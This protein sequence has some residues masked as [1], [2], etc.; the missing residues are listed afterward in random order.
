M[1]VGSGIVGLTTAYLL[2]KENRDVIIIDANTVGGGSSGRNTGKVT[3]QHGLIY[4]AISKKHS[5]K[6]ARMYYDANEEG[7]K[8]VE[9]I[10]NEHNISCDLKKVPSF[11]YTLDENYIKDIKNEYETCKELKIPCNYYARIVGFPSFDDFADKNDSR[12]L[13]LRVLLFFRFDNHFRQ[14]NTGR[15]EFYCKF[16]FTSGCY[17]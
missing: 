15:A 6:K 3:S 16:K 12:I 2:A 8:L 11:V 14:I 5:P 17:F 9:D 1:I 7:M 10:I 13:F 4:N